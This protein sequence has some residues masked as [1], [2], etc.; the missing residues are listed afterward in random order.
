MSENKGL[1]RIFA[2]KQDEGNEQF[3]ITLNII[4]NGMIYTDKLRGEVVEVS[5]RR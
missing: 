5:I 3:R 4:K 1:V 2:Q